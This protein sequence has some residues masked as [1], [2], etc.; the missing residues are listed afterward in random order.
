MNAEDVALMRNNLYKADSS[1][2]LYIYITRTF[3]IIQPL[4]KNCR[5]RK[6]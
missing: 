1:D 4:I 3:K 6:S 2:K 5:S